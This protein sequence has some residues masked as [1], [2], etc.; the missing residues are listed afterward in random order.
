MSAGRLLA[1]AALALATLGCGSPR[2]EPLELVVPAGAS[3]STVTDSL[4]ARGVVSTPRLFRL[5]ARL[6]GDDRQVKSGRYALTPG[7]P[8]KEILDDLTRGRVMTV[9]LTIPEGFRL[10]QIAPRIAAISGVDPDSVLAL[11]QRPGIDSTYGVPGPGLEGYLFPDTYRFAAGVPVETVLATMTRRYRQAWTP[12]R[13]ARLDSLGMSERD[14]VT[15][16]SIVQAEARRGDEMPRIASVYHNR[17]RAGWLLQADPT[18]LYALGGP[19]PR[20][21]Y[22]AIDSVADSPYNTY[23][24]PGLPPGPIGAPGDAA[25]DAALYPAE[26]PY[27]YFVARMDGSHVFT[28]TLAEHNRAVAES[29]RELAEAREGDSTGASPER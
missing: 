6:R 19:R 7:A 14:L 26:E 17:L 29:R 5:Y 13:R 3:F 20:L 16:A 28:R 24:R 9:P 25:L 4:V 11:L 2:G 18:V 21:L 23:R 1:S 15:L 8:W 10:S 27:L 22:A 12:A